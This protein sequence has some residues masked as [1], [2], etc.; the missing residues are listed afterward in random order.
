MKFEKYRMGKMETM[1]ISVYIDKIIKEQGDLFGIFFEDIN[2]AADGGLYG[3][4]VRN[5]SFEFN[6]VDAPGYHE[7]TAWQAVSRGDSVVKAHIETALPLNQANS[8]YL[9]LE[10]MTSGD[11]GG[12]LNEGY[13]G[14]IPLKAGEEYFFSCYYRTFGKFTGELEVRLEDKTGECCYCSEAFAPEG[15]GWRYYECVLH[16]EE[17]DTEARLV[18]LTTKPVRI[19]L[20]MISLFPANTFR[21]RRNGLRA[22]I[23]EMI[24][25]MKPGFMRFPGGCLIHMGSLDMEDRCAMYR[26]KKTVGPLERRPARRNTWGYNQTLGLGFY[27]YFL[28]CE[29]IGA[30]P[31]PVI[32][33]GYDPH[34][35]RMAPLG[36]MQEWID[37]AL[38]LIEFANGGTDTLWG[39]VRAAM[40]HPKSFHLK[41][42]AIGNEE[43]GDAFYERYERILGE[44]KEKY[45][46]V[47]VI[48]S[49]GAGS[50][51][52]VFEKGWQQA[53]RTKTSFVDEHFYQNPEWFLR[54]TERYQSYAPEP[55]AFLGEYAS[56]DDCWGNALA[57][58]AFMT[59]LEKA[60]GVGLA[61]Y[62]PLLCHTD[63][64][65][66]HPNLICFDNHRVFGTPSYYVQKL[67]MN[68]QGDY[69]L[70]TESTITK[71]RMPVSLSGRIRMV[72]KAAEVDILNFDFWDLETGRQI[73][74]PGFSL[75]KEKGQYD[76][77]STDS[78]HYQISFRYC[79]KK[80]GVA[81]NLEGLRS[82]ELQFA[83]TDE[84]NKYTWIIDGW[85]RLTSVQCFCGGH[86][87]DMGL[88]EFES[89]RGRIYEAVL[90][91]DGNH[92]R[93]FI[94]GKAYCDHVCREQIEEISYSA[95][96]EMSGDVI[97]KLVNPWEEE[98]AVRISMNGTEAAFETEVKLFLMS[99]YALSA[100]NSFENPRLVSPRELTCM[101][102][103]KV[104][105]YRVP[106]CSLVVIRFTAKK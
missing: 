82:F 90:K 99:G 26:W 39:S 92:I 83:E 45:P 49:A 71:R 80:G 27:E 25:D 21:K 31:L 88:D 89:V 32:S 104:L 86:S 60:E 35:L 23:A 59:G 103:G 105:D 56:K 96:K 24:C 94:D 68:H 98:K 81:Q 4:L 14:G 76:C 102:D 50:A 67:F 40:G 30:E 9:V 66:W 79:K 11:G 7:M 15:E 46:E 42:L 91:V 61:C 20:D 74:L 41:Y 58:A 69:L 16:P 38:D 19:G 77:L 18:L 5:R 2:H 62:A 75:S 100:R 12:I 63:Y 1:E 70:K 87:A 10:V 36:Q 34:S 85:Q 54:N 8:H 51:G 73:S 101:W 72:T 43:V 65:N 17:T 93:T 95:V 47:R 28:F 64:K 52:S 6:A 13:G 22:D 3:E 37:E 57:E 106:G 97:M 48:N 29:D 78:T 53:K 44:V 84:R 55:K 33:A